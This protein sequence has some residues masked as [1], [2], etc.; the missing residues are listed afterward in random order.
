MFD[1]INNADMSGLHFKLASVIIVITAI[2]YKIAFSRLT[3]LFNKKYIFTVRGKA[4]S[5]LKKNKTKKL[6]IKKIYLFVLLKYLATMKQ[7]KM[8]TN[9][10]K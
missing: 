4:N 1:E 5:S 10:Q 6:I 2:E 3:N 8:S 7:A 9:S